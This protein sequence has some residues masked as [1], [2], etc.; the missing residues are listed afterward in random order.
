MT[1]KFGHD[2]DGQP[3]ITATSEFLI[4]DPVLKKVSLVTPEDDGKCSV[5][6]GCGANNSSCKGP[7]DSPPRLVKEKGAASLLSRL[8]NCAR[9]AELEYALARRSKGLVNMQEVR[10]LQPVNVKQVDNDTVNM[11]EAVVLAKPMAGKSVKVR[12]VRGLVHTTMQSNAGKAR[13]DLV[14]VSRLTWIESK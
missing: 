12:Y 4:Y 3:E 11:E 6:V 13:C 1:Y 2:K 7:T 14:D 10:P 5:Y 9:K 8:Q